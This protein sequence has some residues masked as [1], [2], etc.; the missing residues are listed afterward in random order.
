M[1]LYRER[2]KPERLFLKKSS[3]INIFNLHLLD[4]TIVRELINKALRDSFY[5]RGGETGYD[6]QECRESGSKFSGLEAATRERD[7]LIARGGV[8]RQLIHVTCH[9]IDN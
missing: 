4:M 9:I 7:W 1:N 2:R 3:Q 6:E 8:N 5:R